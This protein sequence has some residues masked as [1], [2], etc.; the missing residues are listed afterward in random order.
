[1]YSLCVACPLVFVGFCVLSFVQVLCII[2]SDVRQNMIQEKIKRRLNSGN[3]CYHSVQNL[4]PSSL[5]LKNI[6]IG[7][8]K[9]IILRVVLYGCETWSLVLREEHNNSSGY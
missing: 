9:T 6:K 8:C 3:V 1:M 4:L 2:L 7:R 5:L